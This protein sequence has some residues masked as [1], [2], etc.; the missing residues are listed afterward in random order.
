M[1][2]SPAEVART[3]A[4]G[5]LAGTAQVAYRPG[6]HQ[7]RHA[8]DPSG[9]LLLLVSIVS[10]LAAVLRPT[11]AGRATAL[12]L[13]VRDLPPGAGTPPLGRVWISGWPEPL[14]GA[15]ARRAA[16]DFADVVPTGDLLDVGGCFTLYR[17]EPVEI[18]LER[19]G[20][21]LDVEPAEYA[22][23]EP[24]PLHPMERDLLADL[25]D[26]HGP[27]VAAF[28]R[29]QL[30]DIVPPAGPEEP[31]P[32]VVRLDRY[33]MVVALGGRSTRCRARL[34]F[35]R[36]LA[37]QAELAEL[38]HPVLCRRRNHP[39]RPEPG[40]PATASPTSAQWPANPGPG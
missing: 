34:A 15:E 13:D 32:R 16:V 20:T 10:D 24:D 38:L 3:L 1:Q 7:V 6:P 28:L 8:T 23:A 4:A 12:V 2:P 40:W 29:R 26:H 35:P 30:G 9:R 11:G 21:V 5:R 18:R 33:G 17:F 22:A 25:A 39:Q 31:P 14:S 36:P 37:N 19:A 27:E